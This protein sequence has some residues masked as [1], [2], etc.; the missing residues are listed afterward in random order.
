[1]RRK[2]TVFAAVSY[3]RKI[4]G[5]CVM[6]FTSNLFLTV[7]L[8]LVIGIV[9][10]FHKHLNRQNV[11][12][13][14]MNA[15]FLLFGGIGGVALLAATCVVDYFFVRLIQ[16]RKSAK[17]ATAL[18]VTAMILNLAP[19]LMFK[20]TGFT[21]STINS[22][23]GTSLAIPQFAVP[24]GISFYTFQAISLLS[25]VKTGKIKYKPSFFDVCFYLSFFTTITS[26]PIV[27]FNDIHEKL[28]ER[29]INSADVSD[30]LT[31]FVLGLSKKVLLANNL[32]LYV[33]NVFGYA[34]MG[35]TFSALAY[36]T[37]SV[38]FTMQ[39]YLDFSGYSDMAIGI[40][41]M[42]GFCIP[43]NFDYPYTAKTIGEFWR[44]WHISLSQWFRDYIYIPLGGNRVSAARHIFNL[45]VVWCL[46]GIWHGAAWTFIAWGLLYFVL[47]VAEKYIP[48]LTKFMSRS[49]VGHI[50]TLFFV[51]LLWIFFRSDS[52]QSACVFVTRMFGFGSL[53]QPV[54]MSSLRI[55][56][57]LLIASVCSFPILKR[58]DKF[59]GKLPFEIFRTVALCLLTV[60]SVVSISGASFTPF[61]Y[62][63]F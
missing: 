24:L 41:K 18:F 23:F 61:I 56:P 40:S 19:L 26:G 21:L 62:G 58:L 3:Q 17:S 50:Y 8:P 55:L 51:N 49:F 63:K 27:R 33:D 5:L 42:L 29:R 13:L 9:F 38:A 12:I 15:V 16:S 2:N 53:S 48:P 37:G 10:L 60:L 35:E 34:E 54:E 25:D 44:K 20:Y 52:I 4:E 1:M 59:K 6:S 22:C 30:G 32:A 45:F 43:E 39:L 36:W 14:I 57:F 28:K 31:R 46:T 7:F 47:L 11:F